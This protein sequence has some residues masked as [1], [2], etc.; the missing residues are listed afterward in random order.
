[1]SVSKDKSIHTA[2][3]FI[4]KSSNLHQLNGKLELVRELNNLY[5]KRFSWL[6]EC[7]HVG[8]INLT[9]NLVVIYADSASAVMYIRQHVDEISGEF[10][11]ITTINQILIKVKPQEK[12][13]AK[14]NIKKLTATQREALLKL[15]RLVDLEELVVPL[16]NNEIE[17]EEDREI[18]F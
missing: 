8:S 12:S 18:V 4:D 15:A 16:Q 17:V 5:R 7:S 3:Y 6:C 13:V 1:L 10:N 2:K 14:K 11:Q 9:Q